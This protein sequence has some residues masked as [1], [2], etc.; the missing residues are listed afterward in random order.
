MNKLINVF[1]FR[2][3]VYAFQNNRTIR[4]FQREFGHF[5]TIDEYEE[6]ARTQESKECSGPGNGLQSD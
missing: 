4:A 5:P 2:E 6:Y 1:L 3:V